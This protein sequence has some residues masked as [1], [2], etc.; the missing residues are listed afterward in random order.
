MMKK[1][2]C[3]AGGKKMLVNIQ[4]MELLL[5]S[6]KRKKQSTVWQSSSKLSR[7]ISKSSSTAEGQV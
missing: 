2:L 4:G 6:Y 5:G 1:G 7:L 3:S